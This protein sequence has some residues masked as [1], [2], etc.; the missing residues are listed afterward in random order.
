MIDDL[1][2]ED[3][4]L[5]GLKAGGKKGLL[6]KLSEA[7]ARD[8]DRDP[9]EVM[10]AIM[11]RERL[12]STGVGE[13]VAIPHARLAG[14]ERPRAWFARLDAPVDFDSVDDV[15]VDLAFLL[16]VPETADAEHLKIL[17]RV[18]RFFRREALRD[19]VR[20]ATSPAAIHALF[21]AGSASEAA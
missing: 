2:T 6:Q 5:T 21:A 20:E 17:A 1:L 12:G 14:I 16:I 4:I 7:A 11:D 3:A 9:A 13:G 10:A 8:L 15:P 19:R 18:S